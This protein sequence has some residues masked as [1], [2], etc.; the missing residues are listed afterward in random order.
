MDPSLFQEEQDVLD[1]FRETKLLAS[2]RHPN[3]LAFIGVTFGA[4]LQDSEDSMCIIEECMNEGNLK[5]HI[6]Q[7][8]KNESKLTTKSK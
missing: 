5:D 6:D 3:I 4:L 8:L 2:S 1:F 7:A